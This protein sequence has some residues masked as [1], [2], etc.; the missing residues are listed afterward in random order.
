MI[1]RT[2]VECRLTRHPC[3]VEGPAR[4]QL[5]DQGNSRQKVRRLYFES[6]TKRLFS[7]LSPGGIHHNLTCRMQSRCICHCTFDNDVRMNDRV[8]DFLKRY[9]H[10]GQDR[11]GIH[12]SWSKRSGMGKY[13]LRCFKA[14]GLVM[15]HTQIVMS[16]SV[17]Q[18]GL[19]DLSEQLF[20]VASAAITQRSHTRL[21]SL[22]GLRAHISIQLAVRALALVEIRFAFLTEGGE[23]LVEVGT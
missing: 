1:F 21:K 8:L 9:R 4:Q 23:T 6:A 5:P 13:N 7:L 18:I 11:M 16:G 17:I 22:I 14:I 20:G 15:Q 2:M 19:Y 10:R 12:M 3:I